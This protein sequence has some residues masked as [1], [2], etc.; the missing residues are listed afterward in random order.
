MSLASRIAGNH[1]L[2]QMQPLLRLAPM[3]PSRIC[4][5]CRAFCPTQVGF[6]A[7]TQF[8]ACHLRPSGRKSSGQRHRKPQQ[9]PNAM[10]MRLLPAHPL[11]LPRLL[12]PMP[13]QSQS[14]TH[15]CLCHPVQWR[16]LGGSAL[17]APSWSDTRMAT[18]AASP[19]PNAVGC[20]R[21]IL[22]KSTLTMTLQPLRQQSRKRVST[23]EPA[24]LAARPQE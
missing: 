6:P 7:L 24:W 17:G 19:M 9:S 2:C 1:P 13:H 14:L 8:L 5:Q 22:K 15:Q 10:T 23:T 16:P 3:S 4:M 12:R 21:S 11:L 20:E 18:A